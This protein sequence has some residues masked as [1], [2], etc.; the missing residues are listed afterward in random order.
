MPILFSKQELGAVFHAEGASGKMISGEGRCKGV[1]DHITLVLHEEGEGDWTPVSS[2]WKKMRRGIKIIAA[3]S[4][5]QESKCISSKW[6]PNMV[7][8]NEVPSSMGFQ[9][10]NAR[11]IQRCQFSF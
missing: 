8:A 6:A 3:V 4:R 1:S 10:R 9:S 7:Y 2:L 5:T 11:T